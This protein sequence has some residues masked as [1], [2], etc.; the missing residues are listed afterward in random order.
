MSAEHQLPKEQAPENWVLL[1]S[2]A[3]PMEAE[4]AKGRLLASGI[5]AKLSDQ[6]TV[7]MA[8]H[9]AD[10]MGG[11]KLRVAEEDLE[12]ALVVLEAE[13]EFPESWETE[14][15]AAEEIARED[16][17]SPAKPSSVMK[18]LWPGVW[19]AVGSGVALGALRSWLG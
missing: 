17:T 7:S 4:L 19:M 18:L 10:A 2:F 14:V 3:V 5:E 1:Q 9:L 11:I 15:G 16:A 12:R 6:H 13:P 8:W